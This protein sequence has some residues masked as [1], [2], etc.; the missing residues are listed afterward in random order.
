MSG[1]ASR[2][3]SINAAGGLLAGRRS[4]TKQPSESP[5][6]WAFLLAHYM[7]VPSADNRRRNRHPESSDLHYADLIFVMTGAARPTQADQPRPYTLL[8]PYSSPLTSFA[9]ARSR[10][11]M[12]LVMRDI[13]GALPPRPPKAVEEHYDNRRP[14]TET[15]LRLSEPARWSGIGLSLADWRFAA[16][17]PFIWM[18]PS[19]KVRRLYA[20]AAASYL[21][22][23]RPSRINVDA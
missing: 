4:F 1:A 11:S 3:S 7:P 2:S 15:C 10:S 21:R 20:N 18:L 6:C 5:A 13:P 22:C 17:G 19:L 8:Q 9:P 23:A 14:R 16:W 12:L